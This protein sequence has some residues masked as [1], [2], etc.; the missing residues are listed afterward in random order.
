M[1]TRK[2]PSNCRLHLTAC[3]SLSFGIDRLRS[4]AAGD[5]CR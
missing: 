5:A 4:H 1:L 3:D 2:G